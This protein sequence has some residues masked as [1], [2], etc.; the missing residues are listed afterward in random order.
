MRRQ[1]GL[2]TDSW[3]IFKVIGHMGEG[4]SEEA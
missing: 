3:G 1:G 4:D 2:R